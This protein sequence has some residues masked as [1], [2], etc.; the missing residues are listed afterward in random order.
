MQ[1]ILLKRCKVHAPNIYLANFMGAGL[2][3]MLFLIAK[4]NA[5]DFKVAGENANRTG[6]MGFLTIKEI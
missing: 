5:A 1:K 6:T 4:S 2:A 3:A